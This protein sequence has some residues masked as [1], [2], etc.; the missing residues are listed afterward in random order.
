MYLA[1]SLLH[2]SLVVR[3]S[4]SLRWE[5]GEWSPSQ[6]KQRATFKTIWWNWIS[7]SLWGLME[8]IPGFWGNWV[9]WLASHFPSC[10]KIRSGQMKSLMTGTKGSITSVFKKG[11]K[12]DPGYRS[13]SLTS[14]PRKI[15]EQI[16]MEAVLKHMQKWGGDLTASTASLWAHCAWPAWWHSLVELTATLHKGR[17]PTGVIYL[18]ICKA[19]DLIS[20]DTLISKVEW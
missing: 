9:M 6:C 18:E 13:V 5:L 14:V 4:I 8:C 12:G 16:L 19:F 11:R 1:I 7:T 3:L 20:D 2:S 15:M 10:L 17:R